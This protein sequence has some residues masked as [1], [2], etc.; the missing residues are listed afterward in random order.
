MALTPKELVHC[1]DILDLASTKL[2]IAIEQESQFKLFTNT[3]KMCV[4]IYRKSFI[5]KLLNIPLESDGAAIIKVELDTTINAYSSTSQLHKL[6]NY[7]QG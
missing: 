1:L 7:L 4:S 6:Y 3:V 5:T 2:D